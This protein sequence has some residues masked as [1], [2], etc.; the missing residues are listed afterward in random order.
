M[1]IM[2]STHMGRHATGQMKMCWVYASSTRGHMPPWTRPCDVCARR[3]MH[4][5]ASGNT[6]QH[7]QRNLKQ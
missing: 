6:K 4:R 7:D 3:Y 5:I 1:I 2:R